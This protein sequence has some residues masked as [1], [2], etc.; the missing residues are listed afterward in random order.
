MSAGNEKRALI[1]GAS[2]RLGYALTA[3]FL[4]HG[5]QVTATE[6]QPSASHEPAR[7]AG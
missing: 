6:R 7:S 1:I 2:R 5:R 3:E 4:D